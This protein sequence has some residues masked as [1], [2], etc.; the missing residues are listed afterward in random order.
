LR[1]FEKRR[2]RIEQLRD[3]V[4]RQQLV[5][6]DVLVARRLS[7]AERELRDLLLQ[8]RDDRFE[9]RRIGPEFLAARIS[10]R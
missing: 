7:A 2:A 1:Q 9:R 10:F 6:C 8:V 5:A 3:A 4:A